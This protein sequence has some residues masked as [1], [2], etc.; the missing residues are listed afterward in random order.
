MLKTASLS[1]IQLLSIIN[2]L[3]TFSV[4][5]PNNQRIR[6]ALFQLKL[7]DQLNTTR[8]QLSATERLGL[9]LCSIKTNQVA[10][11]MT[12]SLEIARQLSASNP[13]DRD[14]QRELTN[15]LAEMDLPEATS[16]AKEC[17][18]RI[19]S[20]TK[21]GSSDWMTARIAILQICLRQK[22]YD[23]GRKLLQITKVLYPELGGPTLKAQFETIEADYRKDKS[24]T[25]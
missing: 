19:E 16:A 4:S 8:D 3:T 25:K 14:V 5:F 6:I 12:K 9:D 15:L 18:R 21:P 17:W 24:G 22:Q 7:I 11:Q 2:E 10:G 1:S 23:E 20:L 13:K